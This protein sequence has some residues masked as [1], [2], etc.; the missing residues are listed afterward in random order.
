MNKVGTAAELN[1]TRRVQLA[2]VAHIRHNYTDYDEIIKQTSWRNA[3]AAVEQPCLDVLAQWRADS[4]E[5]DDPDAMEEILNEVIV[6]PDS[7]DEDEQLAENRT[8]TEQAEPIKNT[9]NPVDEDMDR[10]ERTPQLYG[11]PES[12][13]SEVEYLGN[14]PYPQPQ[15]LPPH[16][17]QREERFEER[18]GQ[19]W[20]EALERRRKNPFRT[21]PMNHISRIDNDRNWGRPSFAEPSNATPFRRLEDLPQQY[22]PNQQMQYV[23]IDEEA[24]P[25]EEPYYVRDPRLHQH[26][27]TGIA[28]HNGVFEPGMQVRALWLLKTLNLRLLQPSPY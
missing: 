26:A 3:R 18:R 28:S 5:D 19:V 4:D 21:I 13:D 9:P 7:D 8:L 2:V 10:P 17:W 1:L 14:R 16:Q 27:D 23:P 25:R 6:I 11:D 24:Y 22:R 12:D 15:T 20:Q